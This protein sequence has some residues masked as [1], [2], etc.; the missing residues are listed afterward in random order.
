[1]SPAELDELQRQIKELLQLGLILPS[2]SPWGAPVLFVKKENGEMRMCI[3][4]RAL[5]SVTV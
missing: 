1:M 2:A 4:Y 5:N 3:D